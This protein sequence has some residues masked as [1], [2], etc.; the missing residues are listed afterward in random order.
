MHRSQFLFSR[1]Q[2]W[3][4]IRKN[5][6]FGKWVCAARFTAVAR[7]Q[8][9]P[10]LLMALVGMTATGGYSACMTL[11]AASNPILMGIGSLLG[12][13]SAQ[14]ISQGGVTSLCRVVIKATALVT[15]LTALFAAALVTF[16]SQL[17]GWLYGPGYSQY[18]QTLS[19]LGIALLV[20]VFGMGADSG[21][22]AMERP[23]IN[24]I[25]TLLGLVVSVTVAVCLA[26]GWGIVSAGVGVF[27]G[28]VIISTVRC[29][30]FRLDC[31][32]FRYA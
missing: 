26:P 15:S 8:I 4:E 22:R 30:A 7:R 28:A 18:S 21:L 11:V 32:N 6:S 13:R 16:G 3:G 12:P 17:L 31:G 23:R 10:W 20:N 27:A 24:F 5:L 1:Q 25:A 9:M 29:G 19:W 14:A 2:V